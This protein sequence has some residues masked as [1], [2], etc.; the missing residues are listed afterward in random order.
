MTRAGRPLFFALLLIAGYLTY[1]VL[2]PFLVAL[3]WA[4]I[5]PSFFRTFRR[6]SP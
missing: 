2:G 6:A 4:A 1:L 3:T 5:L